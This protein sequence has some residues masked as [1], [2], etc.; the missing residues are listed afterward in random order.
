MFGQLPVEI[1]ENRI[2]F[3]LNGRDLFRLSLLDKYM[4]GRMD[5]IT[6]LLKLRMKPELLWPT[7]WLN[8]KTSYKKRGWAEHPYSPLSVDSPEIESL[9]PTLS[10]IQWIFPEIRINSEAFPVFCT[11]LPQSWNTVLF[12][13]QQDSYTA[14]ASSLSCNIVHEMNIHLL[15]NIDANN[16]LDILSNLNKLTKLKAISHS[17]SIKNVSG[18]AYQKSL[19]G[20]FIQTLILERNR[21]SDQ[22]VKEIAA[23]LP[24]TKIKKL[25]LKLN[26]IGDRGA[27]ALF[28]V[29]SKTQ[30]K[31]LDIG[32]NKIGAMGL[33][34]LIEVLPL[35]KMK[36]LR[37]TDNSFAPDDSTPLLKLI[38][39]TEIQKLQYCNDITEEGLLALAA[40]LPKT[41]LKSLGLNFIP[42]GFEE[43]IKSSSKSQLQELL[44]KTKEGDQI[45]A[46]LG[47]NMEYLKVK[48]LEI[49][50][51]NITSAEM[52][53]FI[54]GLVKTEI[55]ELN[56]NDNPI[57]SDGL[58][59]FAKHLP[60]TKIKKFCLN[61]CGY[62]DEAFLYFASQLK[63][64]KL[65][66]LEIQDFGTSG[67]AVLE[68]MKSLPKS[69]KFLYVMWCKT[70]DL[71]EAA[72]I[73]AEYPLATIKYH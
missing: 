64:T 54:S 25:S 67:H 47:N 26:Q 65:V 29:L 49:E 59:L 40:N 17:Y 44:I 11:T 61:R 18:L 46:I 50:K 8:F 62:N 30:I 6:I 57:G 51:S 27:E 39:K 5:A 72:K 23:I 52:P 3:H 45:C 55:E 2:F 37:L 34:A 58:V 19:P 28:A 4:R 42:N 24:D 69:I 56:L 43:F 38:H 71:K 20:S 41:K 68:L 9:I 60:Q 32:N 14:L 35:S 13:I 21:I 10:R 31:D 73:A 70:L 36:N 16:T 15:D 53:K 33:N 12:I 63:E 7:L 1:L 22:F 66:H 48:K